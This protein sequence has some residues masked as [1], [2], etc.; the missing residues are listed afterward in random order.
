MVLDRRKIRCPMLVFV[1][2]LPSVFV[3]ISMPFSLPWPSGFFW[4]QLL[5]QYGGMVLSELHSQVSLPR[6]LVLCCCSSFFLV[7]SNLPKVSFLPA[8]V[9]WQDCEDKAKFLEISMSLTIA[10]AQ[11][12]LCHAAP[13][14]TTVTTGR[15]ASILHSTRHGT[16]PCFWREMSK[17]FVWCQLLLLVPASYCL[18]LL[19]AV[20]S[21][22]MPLL[23][24]AWQFLS[25]WPRWSGSF[26]WELYAVWL[27]CLS[28]ENGMQCV[29]F[30]VR[31]HNQFALAQNNLWGSLGLLWQRCFWQQNGNPIW[32][33]YQCISEEWPRFKIY[34]WVKGMVPAVLLLQKRKILKAI[35]AMV[36]VWLW[37]HGKHMYF[38]PTFSN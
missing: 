6:C 34:W 20:P 22:V 13:I 3:S 30:R 4:C 12:F 23:L 38:C 10:L 5:L 29:F 25:Q 21:M 36:Q 33:V 16:G 1:L 26:E 31:V 19:W 14:A 28:T 17:G 37:K 9:W 27:L 2:L 35:M 32:L 7:L 15:V 24:D 11:W 8:A 18:G